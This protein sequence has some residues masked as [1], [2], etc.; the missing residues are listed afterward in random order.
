MYKNIQIIRL[1]G[2]VVCY[3]AA[4]IVSYI[5]NFSDLRVDG[6]KNCDNN[7]FFGFPQKLSDNVLPLDTDIVNHS[8][9]VK[10]EKVSTGEWKQNVPL[11][12]IARVVSDDICDVWAKSDIPHL[13]TKSPRYVTQKVEQIL[14]KAKDLMKVKPE[15]RN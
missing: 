6:R 5:F 9:F 15:K 2:R 7:I 8:H 10:K 1:Q 14:L 11:C 4:K 3:T 12:Y 13:G